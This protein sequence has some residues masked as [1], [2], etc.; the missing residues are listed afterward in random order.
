[1]TKK[2]NEEEGTQQQLQAF[3][4]ICMHIH[5]HPCTYVTPI[6]MQTPYT[7]THLR[8]P[9]PGFQ[10]KFCIVHFKSLSLGTVGRLIVRLH[11][12]SLLYPR[13]IITQPLLPAMI[14]SVA[15]TELQPLLALAKSTNSTKHLL[16]AEHSIPEKRSS[17][18]ATSLRFGNKEGKSLIIF[19]F[20]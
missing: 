15:H 1:M 20:L 8:I 4:C 13:M 10:H 19:A 9:A 7:H 14:K 2:N 18:T 11:G 16:H 3:T 12:R 5:T 17:V 6:H